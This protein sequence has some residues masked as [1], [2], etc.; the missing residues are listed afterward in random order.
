G[1]RNREEEL[2]TAAYRNSLRLAVENGIKSIAFPNISTGIYRFP[3]EKAAAIAVRTVTDFLTNHSE[4]EQVIFVCFD[5]DNYDLY[6]RIIV[7]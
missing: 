4:I 2:L 5:R 1:G 6:M 3:K 7:T